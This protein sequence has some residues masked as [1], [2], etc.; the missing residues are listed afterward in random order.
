MREIIANSDLKL[1]TLL[2]RVSD[3]VISDYWTREKVMTWYWY[4][5]KGQRGKIT[6]PFSR[7]ETRSLHYYKT[8]PRFLTLEN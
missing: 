2:H 4:S 6:G 1:E 8:V 3:Y 5:E 7:F